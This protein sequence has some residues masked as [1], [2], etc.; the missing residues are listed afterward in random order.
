M[1]D[2]FHPIVAHWTTSHRCVY[3][4]ELLDMGLNLEGSPAKNNF[5]FLQRI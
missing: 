3:L 4:P 2:I 1:S 5:D